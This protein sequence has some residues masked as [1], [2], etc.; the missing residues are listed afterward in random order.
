MNKE[1][2]ALI[3]VGYTCNNNCLYCHTSESRIIKDLSTKEIIRKI[4]YVKAKGYNFII[5]SG[6]E[7]TI[8]NDLGII[9]K[10]LSKN[11]Q[12]F[13]FISNGRMF[14][15]QKFAEKM[16][17]LGMKYLYISLNGPNPAINDRLS[18]VPGFEELIEGIKNL[19]SLNIELIVNVV[20]NKQNQN[21]LKEI[22]DL[23]SDYNVSKIKFSFIEPKGATLK[24]FELLV[25][26]VED[27]AQKSKDAIEYANNLGINAGFEGFPLCKIKLD[28][29]YTD[30]IRTNNIMLMSEASEKDFFETDFE[31]RIKLKECE[32]CP[33]KDKCEGIFKKYYQKRGFEC[34]KP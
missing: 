2:K 6:G 13:G 9:A 32:I 30:N 12:K 16:Y 15:Y 11:N 18:G 26:N 33:K 3:K 23:L 7:P 25:P 28:P 24:N 31:N 10:Y 14:K 17:E 29:K 4:D 21:F 34:E 22:I 1:K 20:V 5:F 8:R 19:S 27:A